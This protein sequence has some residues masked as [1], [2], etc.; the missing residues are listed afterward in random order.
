MAEG[1]TTPV[2]LAT[3]IH[4]LDAVLEGGLPARRIYLV[5]GDPG[6]GKTTLALQF[7]LEGVRRGESALYI[8]LSE[9]REELDGI[10]RSHGWSLEGLLILELSAEASLEDQDTTLYQPSEVELGERMRAILDHIDGLRPARIV[11][12]SCSE[13]RLLAQSELRY[14]RQILALKR[15]LAE[16]PCTIL[17]VDSSPPSEPDTLLQ[18]LVH[19]VLTLEQLAPLYGAERRR[20]RVV[21]LRGLRYRGGHHDFVIR[22]GGLQVFPRLVAA[23]HHAEVLREAVPS[24]VAELDALLSGGPRRGTS[25]LLM[26]PPGCGKSSVAARYA[27]AAAERGERVAMFTFDES[28]AVLRFRAASLGMD[29]APH[30]AR[31]ALTV[32]QVDPAELSPGEFCH[33]VRRAADEGARLVVI[34]SLD[35]YLAAMPEER[36]GALQLHELLG[37][38]AQ[39]GVVTVLTVAQRGLGVGNGEAPIDLSY[40]SDAVLL[41]RTF[42]AAGE[43]RKAVLAMKNRA[44]PHEPTIR[45]LQVGS[46]GLRLGPV[47]AQLRGVLAGVP[48]WTGSA[49]EDA[50]HPEGR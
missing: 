9:T 6:A 26:G 43:V 30:V 44:G 4:G 17:L 27:L 21:K 11:L 37:V 50:N 19:G 32:Q 15:R 24:G 2:A 33:V 28:A 36:L 13:L 3:G 46:D 39:R 45:E 22:A 31:G 16:L 47:L 18:T 34:D 8:S 35:G 49:A 25:L 40:L 7:L 38:L 48:E 5:H 20:L 10:A 14:R 41:F 23:E 1:G 12:D 42:E 29:L